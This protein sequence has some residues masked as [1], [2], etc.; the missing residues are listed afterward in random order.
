MTDFHPR[1]GERRRL[2]RDRAASAPTTTPCSP[3]SPTPTAR[4]GKRAQGLHRRGRHADARRLGPRRVPARPRRALGELDL[5]QRRHRA[6]RR[7]RASRRSPRAWSTWRSRAA[8]GRSAPSSRSRAGS[9]CA[10]SPCSAAP[11]SRRDGCV[12]VARGRGAGGVRAHRARPRLGLGVARDRRRAQATATT[13]GCSNGAKKWIGNGASGGITFVWARVDDPAADE[14]RRG[15]LLPRRAGHPGLH[16]HRDHRARRRCAASTRR[17]SPSTTCACPPMP[18][19]PARRASRMPRPCCTRPARVSRGRRSATPPP[20][21]RPPSPT[22]SSGCSSAGRSR[23]SRWCR[24]ASRR[25]SRSSPRMQLYC[26]LPRRPRDA[27][28]LRPTQAS[29]AKYHNTRAAR[30]IA[31]TARDLLGGNGILLENGVMQHMADIEA[32]HT[33]EG[34]ESV[35]ALLIGRDITGHERLRLTSADRATRTHPAARGASESGPGSHTLRRAWDCFRND[36]PAPTCMSASSSSGLVEP[37][38]TRAAVEPVGRRVRQAR[39]PRD[40]DHRG[41]R[42]RRRHRL[43]HPAA[44]ARHDPARHRAH[45]RAR[46]RAGRCAGCGGAASRR[47]S[48]RSSPC[49]PSSVI[50]GL[51][52]WL[53]V[54]AVRD[55][56]DDLYAQAEEGF[57]RPDRLGAN[58]AVRARAG[59][60]RRVVGHDHRLRHE[61]AV[62][63][64][65][66]RRRRRGRELRHRA[67]ADGHDPVLLPQGRSADVGVPA[68][69]VPRREL[70]ARAPHRRQDHRR[71]SAPTCAAPR[72]SRSSMPSAS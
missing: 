40:P 38:A 10:P 59:A 67:R 16:R 23:S 20:A 12:P 4:S 72:R 53:I 30:R 34:T 55:Q 49:S 44:H 37:R 47:C 14:P 1:P 58:P 69:A 29:L 3:T 8:T 41:R 21:T 32:I 2:R 56:W 15:A 42:G 64:R 63:L 61:R 43:G 51:L 24:S 11:S 6:P 25:C 65:R 5:L 71:R 48:R 18:S 68:A 57:Q 45:P 13:S 19:C 66:P 27:G 22:R 46:V 26:R 36:P 28:G 33:Y 52:D 54:W 7:S 9:R 50:L 62:R 35:Q 60:A 31:A 70:R 39:H 17:T